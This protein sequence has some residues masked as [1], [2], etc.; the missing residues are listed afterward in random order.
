MTKDWEPALPGADRDGGAATL[1][2]PRGA[3][4]Y[5]HDGATAWL[6][7]WI[8]AGQDDERPSLYRTLRV[9]FFRNG[10]QFIGCDGTMLFRTWAPYSDIGDL[11]APP[12][13]AE[14]EPEDAVTVLDHEKF[15]VGFMSTLLA[16]TS[17]DNARVIEL[18]LSIDPVVDE[19]A[20]LSE[21]VQ[22]YVLTLHA[23][24]QRLSCKLFDGAY[25]AWRS[26]E[27]GLD[28]AELVDG[29]TLAPK[30]F[31]ALGK[32]RG[33][34]GVD[35]TFRARDRAI[36]W[37]AVHG[38]VPATGLLMPMR[39]PAERGKAPKEDAEQMEHE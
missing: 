24:G 22:E 35:C 27:L 14:K 34:T 19:Q 1:A 17:G 25:P 10:V 12:P 7:A 6:N 11:P 36:E 16:A 9:E 13:P 31:K 5:A 2:E 21:E 23:L 8:A 30:M 29:M 32:L 39:K 33:V 18:T 20:P 37:E 26:L 3:K 4:V 38:S 15:A 28:A